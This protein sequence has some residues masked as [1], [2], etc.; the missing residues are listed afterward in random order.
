MKRINGNNKGVSIE[1]YR[2]IL[3]DYETPDQKVQ[4]RLDYIESLCR[5]V[6][7][8]ELDKLKEQPK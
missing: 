2:K 7:R 1:T 4:E 6:I 5:N 3:N 8:M